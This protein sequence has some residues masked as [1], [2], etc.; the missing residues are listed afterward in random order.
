[1]AVDQI[2]STLKSQLKVEW[3]LRSL[4][5]FSMKKKKCN[6]PTLGIAHS[7][8]T[9]CDQYVQ[10]LTI[11]DLVELLH[12]GQKERALVSNYQ[13]LTTNFSPQA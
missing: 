8:E 2:V 12:Q 1:M 10:K 3:I 6:C 13:K 4:H 9:L 11:R 7:L 5:L